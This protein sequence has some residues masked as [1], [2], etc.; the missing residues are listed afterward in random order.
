MANNSVIYFGYD[1]DMKQSDDFEKLANSKV[2]TADTHPEIFAIYEPLCTRMGKVPPYQL[3]LMDVKEPIAA[4]RYLI[5]DVSLSNRSDAVFIST[6]LLDLLTSEELE[7]V[8]AHE[9]RHSQDR[10]EGFLG[11]S[12]AKAK[13]Y[14]M[15][16][17]TLGASLRLGIRLWQE[18]K[19]KIELPMSR[20][21]FIRLYTIVTGGMLGGTGA[22]IKA[23]YDAYL[24]REIAADQGVVKLG[25]NPKA[26]ISALE[27][28]GRWYYE[29]QPDL[30]DIVEGV[31]RHQR[32]KALRS[33]PR[34]GGWE[35]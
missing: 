24:E 17:A 21:Y 20:R 15:T 26:L 25:A 19:K 6:G 2:I 4:S 1:G 13:H 10:P 22:F 9:I 35:R 5:P 34:D 11:V 29:N 23:I 27:K 16:G 8:L 33:M 32:T 31:T 30:L 12:S 28:I 14:V 18:K 3:F 7:A